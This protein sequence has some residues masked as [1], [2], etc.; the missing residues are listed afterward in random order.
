[1]AATSPLRAATKAVVA[2]AEETAEVVR[3]AEARVV[4]M[5]EAM[6][7][8]VREAAMAVEMAEEMV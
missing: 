4:A 5:E 8:A 1:M 6:L 7:V 3:V 2:T